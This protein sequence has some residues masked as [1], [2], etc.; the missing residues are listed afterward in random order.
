MYL[1]TY[2]CALYVKT[3]SDKTF[4]FYFTQTLKQDT[5]IKKKKGRMTDTVITIV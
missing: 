5:T 3:Y 2:E 1:K 4:N